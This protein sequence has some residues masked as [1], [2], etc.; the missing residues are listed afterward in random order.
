MLG[1]G[2]GFYGLRGMIRGFFE[3]LAVLPRRKT[4]LPRRR[5]CTPVRFCCA[6]FARLFLPP[7]AASVLPAAV[8]RRRVSAAFIAP[9]RAPARVREI[10]LDPDA[11]V[12]PHVDRVH[13]RGQDTAVEPVD[14]AGL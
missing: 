14:A 11:A 8:P 4:V 13:Q 7:C 9:V 2:G 3:I 6:V 12:R 10:Q 1:S 5:F